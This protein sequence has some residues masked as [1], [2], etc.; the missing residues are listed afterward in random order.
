MS[1]FTIYD[2]DTA[3]PESKA[4]LEASK[5]KFGRVPTMHGIMA[6]APG[7]LE[8]YQVLH[9]LFEATSFNADEITVVWQS[10]NVEHEC[11]YCVPGHTLIAN[12]MGVSAEISDALRNETPLPTPRLEA[13]RDFTLAMVRA[14]GNVDD[15]V[16]QDFF[17]AGFTK[18][19][20][21]EVILGISQKV[22]SNYLNHIAD[23]PVTGAL[24]NFA[25]EKRR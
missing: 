7:L 12:A 24:A 17:D 1:K 8:G 23:T 10:I 18:R 14:R 4:L 5:K 25:W 22:I 20:A 19:Q 2:L 6:E 15:S 9:G 21:M 3:P 11:T 13:L 16:L